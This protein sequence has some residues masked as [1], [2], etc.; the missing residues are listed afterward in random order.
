MTTELLIRNYS[1]MN[2]VVRTAICFVV[3]RQLILSSEASLRCLHEEHLWPSDIC[4]ESTGFWLVRW[5]LEQVIDSQPAADTALPFILL[6]ACSCYHCNLSF[7]RASRRYSLVFRG[8]EA[9]SGMSPARSILMSTESHSLW[10]AA[11]VRLKGQL[12]HRRPCQS[13]RQETDVDGTVPPYSL[14]IGRATETY[15]LVQSH[16]ASLLH[17]LPARFAKNYRPSLLHS[18]FRP[19]TYLTVTSKIPPLSQLSSL[20]V[21]ALTVVGV[22]AA[23]A[24]LEKRVIY[25]PICA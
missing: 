3:P 18:A 13:R 23:A 5:A 7:D 14:L 24:Q 17:S 16:F 20:L 9:T 4:A 21:L 11:N 8:Q 15:N 6:C 1:E 25:A 12:R 10:I 19:R 2:I 22:S